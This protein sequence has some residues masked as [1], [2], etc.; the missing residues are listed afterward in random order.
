MAISLVSTNV[1]PG[2]TQ[3]KPASTAV[4]DLLLIAVHAQHSADAAVTGFAVIERYNLSGVY[5]LTVLG[6]IADGSEGA[7]FTATGGTVVRTAVSRFTGVDAAITDGTPVSA[8]G[9][10]G[11][12][13]TFASITTTLANTLLV[14]FSAAGHGGTVTD[15]STPTGMTEQFE[16]GTGALFSMALDT[17]AIAA[18]GATG[19][20]SS[21]TTYSGG[22]GHQYGVMLALKPA[23]AGTTVDAPAM[24]ATYAMVVPTNTLTQRVDAPAMTATYAMGTPT[25][26]LVMPAPAM[27][28]T[29]DMGVPTYGIGTTADAPAMTA[30]WAMGVP[31]FT[32]SQAVDAPVMTATWEMG[33][34]DLAISA[35]IDAPEMAAIWAMGVPV[36]LLGVT[37]PRVMVLTPGAAPVTLTWSD[38]GWALSRATVSFFVRQAGRTWVFDATVQETQEVVLLL[39]AD[40]QALM[41]AGVA[42]YELRA[43]YDT[44]EQA[45]L[46]TGLLVVAESG[47]IIDGTTILNAVTVTAGDAP[48]VTWTDEAWPDLS[49]ALVEVTVAPGISERRYQAT[50]RDGSLVLATLSENDT[51]A[52]PVGDHAYEVRG[53][54]DRDRTRSLV[55]GVISVVAP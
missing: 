45:T 47:E 16:N 27:G 51:N 14:I 34:P 46:T 49:A 21:T 6:R 37:P 33:T 48:V 44:H 1:G 13:C 12:A 52:L 18:T 2:D 30:S 9:L 19:T 42:T 55:V 53:E 43:E 26:V 32:L 20:R 50:V 35:A 3:S 28:A 24:A 23:A 5:R 54:F 15:I 7:S 36:A 17:Q 22:N 41:P 10:S 31:T 39:T 25:P 29:W 4:G 11:A 38:A 40:D 8:A